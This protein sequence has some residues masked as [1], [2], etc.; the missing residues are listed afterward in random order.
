[1]SNNKDKRRLTGYSGNTIGHQSVYDDYH[2]DTFEEYDEDSDSHEEEEEH[3]VAHEDDTGSELSI[4]DAD[5][6]FDLVYALHT[7]SASVEGQAT[8][9]RGDALTLLDDSNSYWWLVKV[10]KTA[11]VGYIPAENIETPHERLARLNSHRNIEITR[12]DNFDAFPVPP[13]TNPT[14]TR[15][16]VT[17][18]KGVQYQSQII[19]GSSDSEDLSEEEDEKIIPNLDSH[20]SADSDIINDPRDFICY[21]GPQEMEQKKENDSDYDDNDDDFKD[22]TIKISLTPSIARGSEDSR[23]D[24]DTSIQTK[25]KKA[26]KLE[27]LLASSSSPSSS[28]LPDKKE[29]KA[30]G[31]RKFFSRSKKPGS[32]S[33]SNSS[34]N[35]DAAQVTTN[36]T[37]S[38][39]SSQP[40]IVNETTRLK[41][42]PGNPTMKFKESYIDVYPNTTACE[43]IQQIL[44]K[45]KELE[46]ESESS[47]NDYYL[48][49][50]TLSGDECTLIPSDK[51]LEI[52]YSLTAHLNTPMPSL[53]KARRISQMM[54]SDN[55]VGGPVKDE[56]HDE[57]QFFL[58]SKTKRIEDGEIQIK[59]SL[60]PSD[61]MLEDSK[62][63]DKLVKIP[64]SFL[65][66][67][68]VT[69]LLEKFHIL[70]GIVAG[71]DDKKSLRLTDENEIAKYQLAMSVVGQERLLPLNEKLLTVF[72]DD[73]PQIHY[74]RNSNPD[75]SS[76]TVNITPPEKNETYFLLRCVERPKKKE[77]EKQTTE[78]PRHSPHHHLVRQDT[79]M[80]RKE[81]TPDNG[82]QPPTPTILSTSPKDELLTQ[83]DEAIQ[84]TL[85]HSSPSII[86]SSS[87]TEQP[88][89]TIPQRHIRPSS[90]ESILFY[91]SDFGVND[92]MVI[93]R[94]AA[95][96]HEINPTSTTATTLRSEISDVFKDTHSRLDQLEKELDRIMTEAVE[97]YH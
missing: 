50:K 68:V 37:L 89:N 12:K 28:A 77:I 75:R 9:V 27:R 19:F 67:D 42:Q 87:I 17:L 13:S 35:I 82:F 53:K 55:H 45:E 76:I 96:L 88:T 23:R 90:T 71:D 48:I 33:S 66:K 8:V 60:L 78:E 29:K 43:V 63:V 44:D 58:F 85:S 74:R 26:A 15:K 73:I 40:A 83:I 57:V 7:F 4:P 56:T 93:I 31:I 91:T 11:E 18:A 81:P 25:L 22:E 79:P 69:L 59:V 10:L 30:S 94:G 80:P 6:D 49:V 5:I 86:S 39:N 38:H 16:R 20:L 14:K 61:Q 36:D 64:C 2:D 21:Q 32:N 97:V 92:L 52:F 72:G 70:N 65:I 54:G 95:A 1:M 84:D 34:N 46:Q 41:I 24:S 47:Y 62:R 51:P 3:E